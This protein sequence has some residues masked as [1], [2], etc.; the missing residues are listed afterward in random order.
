[1]RGEAVLFLFPL[2]LRLLLLLSTLLYQWTSL[3]TVTPCFLLCLFTIPP[4]TTR[5]IIER[6]SKLYSTTS[7]IKRLTVLAVLRTKNHGKTG[8]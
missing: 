5:S 4:F 8:V 2:I 6:T 1:V 3:V 7:N